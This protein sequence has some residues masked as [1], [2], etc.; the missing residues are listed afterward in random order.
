M[1]V[2]L[3]E[4]GK[5]HDIKQLHSELWSRLQEKDEEFAESFLKACLEDLAYNAEESPRPNLLSKALGL[6]KERGFWIAVAIGIVCP[7]GLTF[8]FLWAA[9]IVE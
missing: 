4:S 2:P 9:L 5:Q 7:L 3:K 1:T 8:F 6:L